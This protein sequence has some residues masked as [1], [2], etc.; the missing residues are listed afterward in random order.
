MG[1][2]MMMVDH[3]VEMVDQMI[4]NGLSHKMTPKS[5]NISESFLDGI[6]LCTKAP[7]YTNLG[8]GSYQTSL[9]YKSCKFM[10]P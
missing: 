3:C 9:L 8:F 1:C 6:H 10:H 7:K 5:Y 4:G 2:G